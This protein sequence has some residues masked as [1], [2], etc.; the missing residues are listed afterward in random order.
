MEDEARVVHFLQEHGCDIL[1]TEF[2]T[3]GVR[4][5][6]AAAKANVALYAHAHGFDATTVAQ[7]NQEWA[8]AYDELFNTAAGF[9]ASSNYLANRVIDLGCPA[10]KV[11]VSP[12]GINPDLFAPTTREIG[13]VLAVG[14]LVEKKAPHHTLA[15]FAKA[16]DRN[17][18]AHLDI[19]GDGP[20]KRR[21]EQL[22]RS[23]GIADKVTMHGAQP[24]ERVMEL[25]ARSSVFAQHSVTAPNG[26]TEGL[27]ISL[28][29]AMASEVPVVATR[30]NGFVETVVEG[31]T[32]FLVEEHD[33][34]TMADAMKTLLLD[35][36]KARTM[37][38]AGRTRVCAKFTHK[39][40]QEC[41]R[42]GMRL[43]CS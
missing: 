42:A 26:D 24:H 35:P 9:F 41:L 17:P 10:D 39:Q 5:M 37:G 30:H 20:L 2:L 19:V 36:T 11:S 38:V 1:L 6:N 32:G 13:R 4:F 31:E 12:C 40:T 7:H 15:A 18:S 43:D 33:V 29:E 27:G 22:I 34:D 28:L 25:M 8:K 14:R 3:E 16:S 21:C 23:L